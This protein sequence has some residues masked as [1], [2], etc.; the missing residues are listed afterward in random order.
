LAAA[1]DFEPFRPELDAVRD[2][3]DRAQG[4]RLA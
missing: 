3:S 4:G 1:V 2:R